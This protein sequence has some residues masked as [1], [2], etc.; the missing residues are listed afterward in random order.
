MVPQN[1]T[2]LTFKNGVL[3]G[4]GY[5]YYNYLV[6]QEDQRYDC[7]R[8]HLKDQPKE[9]LEDEGLEQTFKLWLR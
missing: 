7:P 5:D 3:V 4:K 2:P 1:L 8:N 9:N 6:L